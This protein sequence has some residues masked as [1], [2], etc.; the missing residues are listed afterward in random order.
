MYNLEVITTMTPDNTWSRL[1]HCD[2]Y[3]NTQVVV[4]EW[5]KHKLGGDEVV[6][7]ISPAR[8]YE[9]F[10]QDRYVGEFTLTKV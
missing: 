10:Y 7:K 9:I 6:V 2:T 8:K 3:E 1:I 4:L 5:L